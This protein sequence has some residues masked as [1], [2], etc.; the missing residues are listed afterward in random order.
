MCALSVRWCCSRQCQRSPMGRAPPRCFRSP[1]DF[2]L[3]QRLFHFHD[4][5]C[6]DYELQNCSRCDPAG[7]RPRMRAA[8]LASKRVL[9]VCTL[10]HLPLRFGH[11]MQGTPSSTGVFA[12]IAL[13]S[14]WPQMTALQWPNTPP[15]FD[16]KQVSCNSL[17]PHGC[18]G[19]A[20]ASRE[21]HNHA[22]A[23]HH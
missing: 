21:P 1:R 8:E 2:L 9:A 10:M 13:V 15:S 6:I 23:L 12:L 22:A 7:P 11:H 18:P 16:G 4:A 5:V 17:C 20:A 19:P 14:A 3:Y